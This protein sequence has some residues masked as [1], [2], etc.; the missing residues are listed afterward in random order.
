MERR[1]KI[2]ASL[3]SIIPAVIADLFILFQRL[4]SRP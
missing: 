2:I 4:I 3:V 1:H